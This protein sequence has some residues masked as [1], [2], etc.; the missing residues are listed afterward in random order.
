MRELI[1]KIQ[2]V[3]S[4]PG[5]LLPITMAIMLV[6]YAAVVVFTVVSP[7][8]NPSPETTIP[9]IGQIQPQEEE[10]A[11]KPTL[12]ATFASR[13]MKVC[14]TK[15][16]NAKTAVLASTLSTVVVRHIDSLE[17]QQMFILLVCIE[18][19]FDNK[20][21]SPVGAVGLAQI[22]PKYAQD[23]ADICSLG[24]LEPGDI[25]DPTINL[26]LGACF[27]NH[28]T[29][30]LGSSILAV[31][32]YN[33]GA[34]SSSVKNLAALASPVYETAGYVAKASFLRERLEQEVA[35]D[36]APQDKDQ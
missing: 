33:A 2:V 15:L 20:A 18:S 1:R 10:V 34:N 30:E 36:T 21:R 14:G 11:A 26:T 29:K 27:F 32:A 35:K 3:L 28:L 9:I 8:S 12:D 6:T 23:F 24:K 17:H 25:E 16:S 31:A 7:K 4:E 19:K 5:T 13:V 22:M